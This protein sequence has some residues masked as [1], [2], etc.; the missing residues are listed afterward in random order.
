MGRNIEYAFVKTAADIIKHTWG[1]TTCRAEYI[2]T[3]KN[4]QVEKFWPTIGFFATT[5]SDNLVAFEIS[6]FKLLA[7]VPM[8]ISVNKD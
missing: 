7:E 5:T 8:Y 1:I 2:K 6:D 3:K 4:L